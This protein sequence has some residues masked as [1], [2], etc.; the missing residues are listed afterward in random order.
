MKSNKKD[1]R[2]YEEKPVDIPAGF[3]DDVKVESKIRKVDYKKE[4]EAR[5]DE[6]WAKFTSEISKE[7]K[8]LALMQAEE[9]KERMEDSKASR[10]RQQHEMKA[11]IEKL[12]EKLLENREKTAMISNFPQKQLET[13]KIFQSNENNQEKTQDEDDD[14]EEDFDWR[15]KSL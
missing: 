12:K 6:E 8:K 14:D 13:P 1:K 11:R 10:E 5:L 4:E 9:E 2:K 7:E 3:F 15:S